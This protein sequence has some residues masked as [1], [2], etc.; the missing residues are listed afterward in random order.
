MR[1]HLYSSGVS[2]LSGRATFSPRTSRGGENT[3]TPCVIKYQRTSAQSRERGSTSHKR[4]H[5]RVAYRDSRKREAPVRDTR[6]ASGAPHD[7]DL[8]V[9]ILSERAAR[10]PDTSH[11]VS[12]CQCRSAGNVSCSAPVVHLLC[13]CCTWTDTP[14][15]ARRMH[16]A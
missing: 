12:M 9:P 2:S 6:L 14:K 3:Q 11:K 16:V 15:L 4:L 5:T 1:C 7:I 13:T 10:F 8:L